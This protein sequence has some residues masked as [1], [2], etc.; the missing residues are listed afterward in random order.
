MD[1]N[2]TPRRDY[3][4][5]QNKIFRGTAG[6]RTV[7]LVGALHTVTYYPAWSP[8]ES[9]LAKTL[10]EGHFTP[11]HPESS[12]HLPEK[13]SITPISLFDQRHSANQHRSQIIHSPQCPMPRSWTRPSTCTMK[14]SMMNALRISIECIE[15]MSHSTQDCATTS[16]S[17]AVSMTG[18]KQKYV[19]YTAHVLGFTLTNF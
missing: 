12:L 18:T 9:T 13:A 17:P 11:L 5:A 7:V 15:T 19:N 6:I 1:Q 16:F 3:D 4:K 10:L 2:P 8:L 14:S